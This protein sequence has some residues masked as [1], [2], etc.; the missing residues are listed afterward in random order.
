[1]ML[2]VILITI[3]MPLG[4]TW[5]MQTQECVIQP[6]VVPSVGEPE[7]RNK[8]HKRGLYREQWVL[9]I[10]PLSFLV[11]CLLW[12]PEH[13]LPGQLQ[14]VPLSSCHQLGSSMR[15]TKRLHRVRGMQG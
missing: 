13:D 3:T 10:F 15:C 14:W 11:L 5:R 6:P 9:D 12:P 7:I 2:L 4:P 1:M 8:C